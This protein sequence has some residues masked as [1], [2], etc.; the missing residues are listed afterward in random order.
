MSDPPTTP[1]QR[2]VAQIM[3]LCRGTDGGNS[4]KMYN[5]MLYVCNKDAFASEDWEADWWGPY[6]DVCLDPDFLLDP[7][8]EKSASCYFDRDY[9][10][11]F[12]GYASTYDDPIKTFANVEELHG[13]VLAVRAVVAA[14]K[15]DPHFTR[16]AVMSP[17]ARRIDGG[18][19]VYLVGFDDV[20]GGLNNT[21]VDAVDDAVQ[22]RAVGDECADTVSAPPS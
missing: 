3:A 18:M 15:Q 10:L 9:H 6:D 7:A 1:L 2:K 8:Y 5:L 19:Y 21:C 20:R 17:A 4:L 16:V 22:G 14:L 11:S 12:S 13:Q